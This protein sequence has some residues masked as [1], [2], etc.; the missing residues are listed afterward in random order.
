MVCLDCH[1]KEGLDTQ[2]TCTVQPKM[3]QQGTVEGQGSFSGTV[4]VSAGAVEELNSLSVN[5]PSSP[6]APISWR[7]KG[8]VT[9]EKELPLGPREQEQQLSSQQAPVEVQ[10]SFSGAVDMVVKAVL[11]EELRSLSAE[12]PSSAHPSCCREVADKGLST[13]ADQTPAKELPLGSEEHQHQLSR[14]QEEMEGCFGGLIDMFVMT[15]IK[16]ELNGLSADYSPP[17]EPLSCFSE[18]KDRES[19]LQTLDQI[20]DAELPFGPRERQ[21]AAERQGSFSGMVDVLV[22][23]IVDEELNSLSVNY[24]SSPE[25]LSYCK[26]GQDRESGLQVAGQSP[27]KELPFPPREDDLQLSREVSTCPSESSVQL[28]SLFT[29]LQ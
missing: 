3:L 19:R 14:E 28:V 25:L 12:P 17:T 18:V 26:E 13:T 11:E 1:I 10:G 2:I 22:S 9:V 7:N 23:A 24:S 27:D 16:E 20:L 29:F 5:Y 21:E 4:D 8:G 6:P 15:V